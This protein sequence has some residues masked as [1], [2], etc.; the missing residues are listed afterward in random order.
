MFQ[1]TIPALITPFKNA[2]QDRPEIDFKTL[3][4][5]IEWQLA[6]GVS[7]LCVC[8]TTAEATTL[9]HDEKIAI[10]KHVISV[11]N[12]RVP[13]I[14]GTGSNDTAVTLE[15][16]KEVKQL[17]A[18]GA[19]VVSP[20]YNK[21]T[22]E[23]LYQHFK[24]VAQKGGLPVVLYNIPGR[25]GVAIAIETF[26]RLAEIKEIVG[27]KQAVDSADALIKLRAAVEDKM[28]IL[29]GDC[30]LVYS[31]LAVG[32]KGTI[33][34]SANVIPKEMCAITDAVSNGDWEGALN[35]QMRVLGMIDALFAET[36]PAPA[37]AALK[38]LGKIEHETLRLPLVSV[39]DETRA[40][41]KREL[42]GL[43][44]L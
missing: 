16:T 43:N 9:S 23:G 36:N 17:G 37:K 41:V 18:D 4:S 39:K 40:L 35:A 2:P 3:E 12:S 25:T 24:L 6:S 19:L 13:V 42:Q 26:R 15:F 8:G 32:G 14:V 27:V 11:N 44:L 1:G 38:L 30:S 20:Y 21:P 10:V 34:A 29:S 33:T 22:Q 7:G 5:L 28:D 31:M